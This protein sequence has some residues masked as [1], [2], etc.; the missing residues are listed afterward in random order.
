M[1]RSARKAPGGMVFH[2][3]NRGV[4]R[5]KIFYKDRDYAAFEHVLQS[6]LEILPMRLLAYCLMPTH[7]HLVI[8]VEL[9]QHVTPIIEWIKRRHA[10]QVYT[11]Y[12]SARLLPLYEAV[13]TGRD[14]G[15]ADG[16]EA[17]KPPLGILIVDG[18]HHRDF[19]D[20]FPLQLSTIR[21]LC[22]VDVGTLYSAEDG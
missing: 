11:T 15:F 9:P 7:W 20:R 10:A 6:T 4:G 14:Q 18:H 21:T 8:R 12:K 1:P 17:G 19:H 13:T 3:L 16:G 5:R 2:V 22:L